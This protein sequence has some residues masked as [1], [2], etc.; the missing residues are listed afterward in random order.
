MRSMVE[1]AR[2]SPTIL[3]RRSI[4]VS[5]APSSALGAVP[6]PRFAGRMAD[7]HG[8]QLAA[9][10]A[11]LE[12]GEEGIEL[13]EV[14]AVVG[15]ELLDFGNPGGVGALQIERRDWNGDTSEFLRI[16][17]CHSDNG[18]AHTTKN[19]LASLRVKIAGNKF[20]IGAIVH[21][22]TNEVSSEREDF[23][24]AKDGSLSDKIGT[25]GSIEENITRRNAVS[26]Y[27][28]W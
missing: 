15:F 7:A 10:G 22:Q 16:D 24:P 28:T 8:S 18:F 19:G 27:V 20:R 4:S 13:G 5:E 11:V 9:K 1:G 12:R 2:A 25:I 17:V 14:G 3:Q 21:A 6:L 26:F 23:T